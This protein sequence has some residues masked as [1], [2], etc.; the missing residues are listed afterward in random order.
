MNLLTYLRSNQLGN[1][2]VEY[3]K[4]HTFVSSFELLL[5]AGYKLGICDSN[6]DSASDSLVTQTRRCNKPI[7]VVLEED[8]TGSP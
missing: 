4:V 3:T 5:C 8:E 6:C 2:A 7:G 1:A